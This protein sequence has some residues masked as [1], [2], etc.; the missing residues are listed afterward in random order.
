[1]NYL[2]ILAVLLG[3]FALKLT[4][5]AALLALAALIVYSIAR[6]DFFKELF[7]RKD[8]R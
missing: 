8:K 4:K 5:V 1:V 6:S 2:I 3:L 7:D